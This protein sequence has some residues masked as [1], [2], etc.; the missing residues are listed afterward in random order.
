[1]AGLDI[2]AVKNND[3]ELRFTVTDEAGAAVNLTSATIK[4]QLKAG[5]GETALIT[6]TTSSGITITDA[7]AGKFTVDIA[8]EDTAGLDPGTY[9]HEAVVVDSSGE[10]VTLTSSNP[11]T[12]GTFVLREQ[13]TV[14]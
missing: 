6:K 2:K 14:Q 9:K 3:I 5:I 1:M 13:L 4:W 8:N 10:A 7:A 11:L 12:I